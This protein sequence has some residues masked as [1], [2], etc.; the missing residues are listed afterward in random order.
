MKT[1][2]QCNITLSLHSFHKDKKNKDGL[3][4]I[5]RECRSIRK[6]C[7]LPRERKKFD[8]NI[9]KQIRISLKENKH[10]RKW[11]SLL[12]FTLSDLKKHLENQFDD[13]MNWN[14]Y[15]SYW[16]V[17]KIIPCSRYT[18]GIPGEFHK[19][20]SLKNLRPLY[21]KY[22]QKKSNKIY[23]YLVEKYSLYDILPIGTL[24]FIKEEEGEK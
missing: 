15:G 23:L 9:K 13:T 7:I 24:Y 1:C 18:Y 14:N 10:G 19:C 22:C 2:T 11:E 5:C 21:K 16:W 8:S 12:G 4:N 3:K 6:T 20:W 17:D